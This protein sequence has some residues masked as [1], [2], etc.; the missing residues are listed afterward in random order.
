MGC[1]GCGMFRVWVVQDGQCRGCEMLGMGCCG[2]GMSGMWDVWDAG[3][4]E[5]GMLG[6]CDVQD[7]GCL[8]GCAMLVYKMPKKEQFVL[9]YYRALPVEGVTINTQVMLVSNGF[10]AYGS[11]IRT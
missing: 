3:Y 7:V 11:S 1:S 8:L 4:W 6:M 9:F 2:S 5:C 10:P